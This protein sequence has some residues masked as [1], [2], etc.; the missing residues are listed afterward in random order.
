VFYTAR[1]MQNGAVGVFGS[2]SSL[3]RFRVKHAFTS[4]MRL[5]AVTISRQHV[6]FRSEMVWARIECCRFQSQWQLSRQCR[7]AFH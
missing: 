6:S 3:N 7:A 2:S 1:Q 5:M 4:I